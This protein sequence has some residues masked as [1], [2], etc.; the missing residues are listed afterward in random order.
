MTEFNSPVVAYEC[1]SNIQAH[2]L[3]AQLCD[4]HIPAKVIEDT[5]LGGFDADR[6]TSSAIKAQIFVEKN[7][8]TAAREVLAKLESISEKDYEKQ[9]CFHCGLESI[10]KTNCSECGSDLTIGDES[11]EDKARSQQTEAAWLIPTFVF[12]IISILIYRMFISPS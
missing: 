9:F 12:I 3:A 2:L 11:E 7:Q 6:S 8:L 5:S 10:S 1:P 4:S